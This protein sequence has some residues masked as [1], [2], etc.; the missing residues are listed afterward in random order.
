[1]RSCYAI[2]DTV[3]PLSYNCLCFPYTNSKG[4]FPFL[5]FIVLTLLF[6]IT[7]KERES[8]CVCMCVCVC[9][10]VCVCAHMHA[11]M[12]IHVWTRCL[13]M[14]VYEWLS[15]RCL[16]GRF[17]NPDFFDYYKSLTEQKCYLW[18]HVFVCHVLE[19]ERVLYVPFW[20]LVCLRLC[21][22]V[23]VS[24]YPLFMAKY[25]RAQIVLISSFL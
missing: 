2:K 14:V 21:V 13:R 10:C 15:A 4:F 9:V 8:V 18:V 16:T 22:C 17:W 23:C 12:S 3:C 5:F 20:L 11:V 24:V 19:K 6:V 1:M 7:L 25:N